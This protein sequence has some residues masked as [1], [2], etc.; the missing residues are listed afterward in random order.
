MKAK[1]KTKTALKFFILLALTISLVTI[2][3][4]KDT[5]TLND[6]SRERDLIKELLAAGYNFT[7]PG[8][9]FQDPGRYNKTALIVHDAEFNLNGLETFKKIESE[10]GISSAL[11]PRLFLFQNPEHYKRLLDARAGFE[12]GY[13][14]ECLSNNNGNFNLARV[15]FINNIHWLQPIFNIKTTSYHGDVNKPAIINLNLYNATLWHALGLEEIYA[16]NDLSY[17]SDT[18]NILARPEY[19]L[20]S[21]VLIQLHTDWTR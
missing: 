4:L 3:L 1:T 5:L 13:Q 2:F 15:E 18:N 14:Q 17:F 16:I 9:Y 10:Y 8:E 7:T 11:Y 20:K 12:V 19:P 21:L 6:G